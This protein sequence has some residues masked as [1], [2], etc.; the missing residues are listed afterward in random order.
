MPHTAMHCSN[1]KRSAGQLLAVCIWAYQFLLPSKAPQVLSIQQYSK[2][3]NADGSGRPTPS[4]RECWAAHLQ[5]Q[6]V[7]NKM[8][9]LFQQ[10]SFS[11]PQGRARRSPPCLLMGQRVRHPGGVPAPLQVQLSSA[12]GAAPA[13]LPPGPAAKGGEGGGGCPS[14]GGTGRGKRRTLG[15]CL[16]GT[17][18]HGTLRGTPSGARSASLSSSVQPHRPRPWHRTVP[19][20]SPPRGSGSPARPG[21]DVP[22]APQ[23]HGRDRSEPGR[24]DPPGSS[25]RLCPCSPCRTLSAAFRGFVG[26]PTSC[27]RAIAAHTR[28][29]CRLSQ[30]VFVRCAPE[31]ADG[32]LGALPGQREVPWL[33]APQ[34]QLLSPCTRILLAPQHSAPS[35][36]LFMFFPLSFGLHGT[37]GA[38]LPTPSSPPPLVWQVCVIIK[39]LEIMVVWKLKNDSREPDAAHWWITRALCRGSCAI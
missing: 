29:R 5:S 38:L 10:T 27:A 26:D 6:H 35:R 13:P 17:S 34:A 28:S 32:C 25:A 30:T 12:N 2:S 4:Q 8:P 24:R 15:V 37:K 1:S 22:S 21:A 19:L 31:G 18:G 20:R 33:R 3:C 9:H 39:T 7:L 14:S 23:H 16:Q 36:P 11:P